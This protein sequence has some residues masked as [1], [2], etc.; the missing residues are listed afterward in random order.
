[1]FTHQLRLTAVQQ[2]YWLYQKSFF[3]REKTCELPNSTNLCPLCY[4][5]TSRRDCH[6][7]L[8]SSRHSVAH[9]PAHPC[10]IEHGR[11][12]AMFVTAVVMT[13]I[14]VEHDVR[15]LLV[16]TASSTVNSADPQK[17]REISKQI[18]GGRA[19]NSPLCRKNGVWC[20]RRDQEDKGQ[21]VP[22]PR[23]LQ[24]W[25]TSELQAGS[26]H[27]PSVAPVQISNFQLSTGW[28]S[29]ESLNTTNG[30]MLPRYLCRAQNGI[31][32]AT[33]VRLVVHDVPREKR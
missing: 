3:L 20:T 25:Q 6:D 28:A 4:M 27:A 21:C 33:A 19:K 14:H 13:H 5:Q 11:I 18:A 15:H 30:G 23:C 2:Q 1:M 31:A 29:C 32:Q 10:T 8:P 12:T 24:E 7:E 22:C 17:M 16:N 9:F 26:C